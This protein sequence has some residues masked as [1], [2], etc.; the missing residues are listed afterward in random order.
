MSDIQRYIKSRKQKDSEFAKKY[1][2][3]YEQF[4]IG[5]MIRNLRKEAWLTQESLA[6]MLGSK[7]S[8]IS[9]MENHAEDIK[10]ST[11][12]HLASVLGKTIKIKFESATRQK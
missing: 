7:K 1:D 10:L 4:K 2:E 12:T 11:L 3:G 8:A 5:V 6:E 9:R